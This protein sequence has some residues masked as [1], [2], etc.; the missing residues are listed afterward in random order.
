MSHYIYDS[1][2]RKIADLIVRKTEDRHDEIVALLEAQ[3]DKLDGLM[4]CFNA[5][6]ERLNDIECVIVD[7]DGPE[8]RDMK[9]T[10]NKDKK[11]ARP[12][13]PR[14]ARITKGPQS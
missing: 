5:L 2:K 9:V 3:N 8:A 14:R 10:H 6:D 7:P 4:R 1:E 13:D 11:S 12:I